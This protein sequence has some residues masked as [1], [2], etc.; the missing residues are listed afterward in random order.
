MS[1]VSLKR[2]PKVRVNLRL[3]AKLLK[4]AKDR[5]DSQDTTLTDI[6]EYGLRLVK[7]SED[8]GGGAEAPQ[9]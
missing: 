1:S 3:D 8:N 2:E 9:I 5:A 6:I 7:D 4:W